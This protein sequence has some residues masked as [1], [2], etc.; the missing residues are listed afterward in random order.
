MWPADKSWYNNELQ[1]LK[2]KMKQIFE[3]AKAQRMSLIW[4][5]FEMYIVN[6]TTKSYRQKKMILKNSIFF[7]H[8]K[9]I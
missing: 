2:C 6:I 9:R 3:Y 8:M 5:A 1:K 4:K 7:F